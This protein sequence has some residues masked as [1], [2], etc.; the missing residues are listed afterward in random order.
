[1][2]AQRLKSLANWAWAST[3][4]GGVSS[5]FS[6]NG[7]MMTT[8]AANARHSKSLDPGLQSSSLWQLKLY[9]PK[10]EAMARLTELDAALA[11][12]QL[13]TDPDGTMALLP[14]IIPLPAG[15]EVPP[16]IRGSATVGSQN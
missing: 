6:T 16:C 15:T 8:M 10:H 2:L 9:A 11:E 3:H 13:I 7:L 4:K 5:V 14:K 12:T 1:M